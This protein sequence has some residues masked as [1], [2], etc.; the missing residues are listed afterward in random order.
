MPNFRRPLTLTLIVFL[1]LVTVSPVQ[2][3]ATEKSS[4][5]SIYSNPGSV[6]MPAATQPL[7]NP[8][9]NNSLPA[10]QTQA[11]AAITLEQAVQIV[12]DN[13]T[14]PAEC[15]N[16]SSGYNEFNSRRSYS[17]NWYNPSGPGSSFNASVDA[18]TGV[19]I[20]MNIWQNP[21][22]QQQMFKLPTISMEAAQK[23][24]TDLV[25]RLAKS[26]LADL[27][28]QTDSGQG[29]SPISD[30]LIYNF[31][32]I[33]LV[34][35]IPFP[36]NSVNVG[37]RADTGEVMSYYANWTNAGSFPDAKPVITPQKAREVFENKQM[38]ELQYYLPPVQ[39]PGAITEKPQ[40]LLV[41]RLADGYYGGAVDALSG[42][43][44]QLNPTQPVMKNYSIGTGKASAVISGQP[45]GPMPPEP[46]PPIKT[47]KISKDEAVAAVQKWVQI[48]D[49]LV[50]QNASLSSDWQY[51]ESQVWNLNWNT[52]KPMMGVQ[53][54]FMYARVN[55]DTGELLSFNLSR[56]INGSEQPSSLTPEQAQKIAEDFLQKIQPDRWQ[57]VKANN[58]MFALKQMPGTYNFNYQRV[59]NGITVPFNGMNVA[60]DAVSKSV[61]NYNLNW[62]ANAVFPEPGN[63]ID[64]K[65]AVAAFLQ[66]RPLTLSYLQLFNPDQQANPEIRLAYIPMANLNQEMI[67]MLDAQT[68]E[69]LDWN[70]QP[71]SHWLRSYQFNDITGNFA[72]KEISVLG[73]TGIFGEYGDSFHPDENITV[74]SLLRAM[75][76]IKNGYGNRLLPT[77][78]DV[79]TQAKKNG[80]LKEDLQPGET[81]SREN[82]A[83]FI[84]RLLNM[85]QAAQVKG[86]YQT[87]FKDLTSQPPASIGYIALAWGL[88][89]FKIDSD[90][91][92]PNQTVTRAD[93]AYA[94][95]KAFQANAAMN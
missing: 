32:W 75:S 81:V 84:V 83:K 86:I 54:L 67:Q 55:A 89:T 56:Q 91:F 70:G 76:L 2:A 13:F 19:I 77:D 57:E 46:A 51:S 14:I 48:P 50:L 90:N 47:P 42:E 35:G 40:A 17:L 8:T 71:R 72:E 36:S 7:T 92:K 11:P 18:S 28:L 45:I 10:G 94:L 4:D 34:N 61:T 62:A 87:P 93:A 44:I 30:P 39:K 5:F 68:G 26:H 20:G 85:E 41:Y 23:T 74:I 82:L 33:R 73:S 43:P 24:A 60:V 29:L 79:L 9:N 65:K 31:R 80:L 21:N 22:N 52:N 15:T 3:L 53:P 27:Q 38:L 25:A 63:A 88:G 12:K 6:T 58:S 1:F 37:V 64:S 16:F 78:D 49:G 66:E 69:P 59:V 95:V